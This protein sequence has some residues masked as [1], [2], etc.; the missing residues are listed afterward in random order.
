MAEGRKRGRLRF[1]L[2][3]KFRPFVDI[4]RKY[5]EPKI[6]MTKGVR[7]ALLML[8]VYLIL[9]IVILVFKFVTTVT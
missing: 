8:R 5:K 7:L 1:W 2:S 6:K 4:S 3:S 9:M